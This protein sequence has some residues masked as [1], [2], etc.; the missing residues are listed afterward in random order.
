MLILLLAGVMGLS[1]ST[2]NDSG[3]RAIYLDGA[4]WYSGDG[5]VREGLRK[6][7]FPGRVE[8]FGWSSMLGPL[9]DHVNACDRHPAAE[10]LARHVTKLRR[11]GGKERIVLIG[12]SAGTRI[13]ISALE[14][15]PDE[16]S[17]DHVVLLS[18]SVSSLHDLTRSLP[19]VRG[20]L[21]ATYSAHDQLLAVA[22]SAGLERGRPA[23]QVGFKPPSDAEAETRKLYQKVVSLPWRPEYIAYGWDGGHVSVT[24]PEFIR[25]VI[26]P[27]ILGDLPH[28]LDSPAGD[29]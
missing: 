1:C 22:L 24:S 6:A 3:P 9:H 11:S 18:P 23:G 19:H 14:R 20:R 26:A 17:V 28:P 7:G 12:L 4:G 21:Y 16:V 25:A 5:P 8:R 10:K 13:I 2:S 15:L 27:R 29:R